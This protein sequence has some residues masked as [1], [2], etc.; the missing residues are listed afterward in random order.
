MSKCCCGREIELVEEDKWDH[1]D[2]EG[3]LCYP[4]SPRSFDSRLVAEPDEEF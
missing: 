1:V 4:D 2:G 3:V